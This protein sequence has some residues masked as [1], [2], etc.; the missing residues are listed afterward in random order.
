MFSIP[1][2]LL[3]FYYY[4]P[5]EPV[6]HRNVLILMFTQ[7]IATCGPPVVILLTGIIGTEIAPDPSLATL[8]SALMIVGIGLMSIPAALLMGKI[9]R[10]AGFLSAFSVAIGAVFCMALAIWAKNFLFLCTALFVFGGTLSFVS[11][12]RFAAAESVGPEQ[13]GKAVSIILL[14]GILAA[15]CGP[16]IGKSGKDLL[17]NAPYVG[18]F[19]F[20]GGVYCI[21]FFLLL[22]YEN[23]SGVEKVDNQIVRPLKR[24]AVQP[25]YLLA[26]S[27]AAVS[28]VVMTTIMTATP[29]Q[30]HLVDGFPL[31]EVTMIIQIHMMGMYLPSLITGF[32]ISR[33][34]ITKLMTLG[35]FFF[36]G[37]VL[38]HLLGRDLIHYAI[39]L[40]FLGIGWNFL[41]VSG[42]TLLTRCY[43][44]GERFK[45]QAINDFIVFGS[46]AVASLSSGALVHKV[47]WTNLN[48]IVVPLLVIML[49]A[50]MLMSTMKKKPIRIN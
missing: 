44:F 38:T 25:K 21:G 22:F 33:L 23:T 19:L 40:F 20:L 16:A 2:D 14:G 46:M 30:M 26:V 36:S 10:K 13:V 34:G 39:G 18:S 1:K 48:L 6:M 11:Q 42:T 32:M 4:I 28:Y 47:G 29:I 12:F 49:T 37:S 41:F 45:A 17:A 7:A 31:N 15:Y 50:L 8:P 35:L 43:T 3:R 5:E 27:G 24:I 9:G